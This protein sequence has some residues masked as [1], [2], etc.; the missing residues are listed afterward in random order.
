MTKGPDPKKDPARHCLK[1]GAWPDLDRQ[2]WAVALLEGDIFEPTGSAV[3]WKPRTRNKVAVAYGR[4]LTWLDRTGGLDLAAG[5]AERVTPAKVASYIAGL[6]AADNSPY[7]VLGRIRD[8]INTMKAMA[9]DR[10]WGWLQ[11]VARKLRRRVKS[12]RNKKMRVVPSYDLWRFGFELM[13][14]AEGPA[15]GSPLERAGRYRSGLMISLLAARQLRRRNFA[16]IEIGRHLIK[17]GEHYSLRFEGAE[18]KTGADIDNLIPTALN[19][20]L[21]RYLSHYRPF[22]AE[23]AGRWKNRLPD[24]PSPGMHLWVSNYASAMSEG[25]IYEQIRNLTRAKFGRALNPHLFRDCAATSVATEDPEHVFIVPSLLG[26]SS[27]QT[28]QQYYDHAQSNHAA[29][30]YQEFVLALRRQSR[31]GQ[32]AVD[33]RSES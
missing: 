25:A 18:T 1:I 14:E 6:Q 4:W 21:E 9:P 15:G 33:H 12:V 28:S 3:R 23:R 27:L 30:R 5:P 2:A 7:T 31:D 10:D 19:P 17:E 26:H 11:R 8:L 13:E 24:L 22:L 29:S 32:T 16:S 20:Y